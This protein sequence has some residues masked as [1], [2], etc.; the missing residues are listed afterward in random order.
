MDKCRIDGF[1]SFEGSISVPSDYGDK[2]SKSFGVLV[3][4]FVNRRTIPKHHIILIAGGPGGYGSNYASL[5]IRLLLNHFD[6]DVSV[7]YVENCGL[8]GSGLFLKAQTTTTAFISWNRSLLMHPS[9]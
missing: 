2:D 6:N 4:K 5:M 3:R 1:D 8:E 7:Y 9:I